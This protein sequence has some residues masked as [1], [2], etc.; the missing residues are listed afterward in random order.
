MDYRQFLQYV[1]ELNNAQPIILMVGK[2]KVSL[3]EEASLVRI[4]SRL[5]SDLPHCLF[6]SGNA[7]GADTLFTEG[8]LAT[9]P[10]RMQ[11]VLPYSS[12]KKGSRNSQSSYYALEPAQLAEDDPVVY[13]TKELH[14]DSRRMIPGYLAGE[15]NRLTAK[16]PYLLRD[17]LMVLGDQSLGLAPASAAIFYDDLGKPMQGGTGLTIRLC[18]QQGILVKNQLAWMKW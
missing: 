12:H 10:E 13:K 1:N 15:K 2:R 3:S 18:R 7:G 9:A 14:P 4:A 6:R 8:V 5:A 16:A 17:T 11:L